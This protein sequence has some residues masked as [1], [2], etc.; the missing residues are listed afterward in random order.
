MQAMVKS[1]M[2]TVMHS[3]F[4]P[5]KGGRVKAWFY[6]KGNNGVGLGIIVWRSGAE[7]VIG[8]LMIKLMWYDRKAKKEH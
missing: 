8:C 7:I 3:R 5:W 1:M 2:Q 6:P 4:I